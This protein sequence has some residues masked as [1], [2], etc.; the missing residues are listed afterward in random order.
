MMFKQALVLALFALA[1]PVSADTLPEALGKA[2]ASHPGVR[3][4]EALRNASEEQLNQVRSN[5]YPILGIDMISQDATD[6]DLGISRDRSTRRAD[7]FLRW[8]LFRGLGDREGE[9]TAE[10]NA[11]AARADLDAAGEQAALQITLAYLD[12]LRL[13]GILALD[14]EFQTEL[15]RLDGDMAK[16][17][18][19]G[20]IPQVDKEQS[21][22]SLIQAG[23]RQAQL[24]G[25]LRGAEI[26]YRLLVGDAPGVLSDV[27]LDDA[28]A[29]LDQDALLE[30][31]LAGNDRL[32]GSR[33]RSA[34][35]GAEVGVAESAF[36]PRLELEVRRR[37][38]NDV[39]PVPQTQTQDMT[40]FQFNYQIP[41]G[42]ST[43]SRKREAVARRQAAEAALD[44][45]TLRAQSEIT[46]LWSA[47]RE[48]RNIAPQLA[49]RAIASESVVKAFDLQFEAGRRS[50]NE[51]I[52]A[53]SEQYRARVDA[54][55]NRME[56]LSANARVLALLGRLR[57]SLLGERTNR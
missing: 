52:G 55:E 37:L 9:R 56:Q 36:Y 46:Q 45:E 13:R 7:A 2:L 17:V 40:Q 4:G 39:D 38:H 26:R 24:Q 32:R 33:Q 10:F 41:L 11:Q 3:S 23:A 50:L 18:R 49:E 35:R 28:A 42:G 31:L 5:F 12:V 54:L 47:W 1:L 29:Q 43:F 27:M 25:Q 34:A 14:G 30:G 53:R 15:K 44:E 6:Q 20:R 51:L 16:R 21:R 57:A 22:A 19:V 48:A 8:N